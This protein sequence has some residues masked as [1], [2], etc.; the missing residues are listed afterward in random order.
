ML[1]QRTYKACPIDYTRAL[2]NIY[3]NG[4]QTCRLKGKT[5]R[6]AQLGELV[7]SIAGEH[8]PEHDVICESEPVGEKHR[9]GETAAE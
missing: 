8:V 7:Y 6:D 3:G 4:S 9:E 5:Y 2:S 1:N